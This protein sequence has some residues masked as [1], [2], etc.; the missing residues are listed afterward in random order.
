[1]LSLLSHS[2]NNMN[3]YFVFSISSFIYF[4]FQKKVSIFYWKFRFLFL[5]FLYA[6]FSF[7]ASIFHPPSDY[8]L[9]ILL[10]GIHIE[11]LILLIYFHNFNFASFR[12]DAPLKISI[13]TFKFHVIKFQASIFRLSSCSDYSLCSSTVYSVT[14]LT[15]LTF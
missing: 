8:S 10:L 2:R 5:N 1:M 12:S 7:L 15:L 3:L 14:I 4:I 11:T 13:F 6:F 9:S